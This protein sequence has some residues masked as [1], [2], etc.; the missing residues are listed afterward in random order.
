M[1]FF[2]VSRNALTWNVIILVSCLEAKSGELPTVKIGC[3]V[4]N[5]M[6]L[7]HLTFEKY[8]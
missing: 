8:I 4:Y 3:G 2:L 6:L 7:N 1:G 5:F